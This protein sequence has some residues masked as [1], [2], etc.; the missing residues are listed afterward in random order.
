MKACILTLL[1]LLSASSSAAR[2]PYTQKQVIS[3]AKSV[4]VRMLDASL[5][6][7]RLENWLESGPPHVH[8][9]SYV[10][11]DT[12]DLMPVSASADYPLCVRIAFGREKVRGFF[13]VRV[14]SKSK[15]IVGRPQVFGDIIMN[16]GEKSGWT[17]TRLSELPAVL[18]QH[19]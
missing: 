17:D 7:E 16:L 3:Y 13:L 1:S 8:V 12:C 9:Y 15:G 14:G 5:P 10:V 6:S 4:D 2:L 19:Q 11:A 18:D